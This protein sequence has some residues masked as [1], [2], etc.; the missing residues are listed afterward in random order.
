LSEIKYAEPVIVS[1]DATPVE[2]KIIARKNVVYATQVNAESARAAGDKVKREPFT[3]FGFLK[4]KSKDVEF[5]SMNK[6]YEPLMVIRGRYLIDYFRRRSYAVIVDSSMESTCLVREF[7]SCN[8]TPL[9][10]GVSVL[11]LE[12]EERLVRQVESLFVLDRQGRDSA[13]Q[14]LPSFPREEDANMAI[15][16]FGI[17][18]VPQDFDVECVRSRLVKRPSDTI[19]VVNEVFAV[20]E[21][22]V[23]YFPRFRLT[24]RDVRTGKKGVVEF[25]GVTSKRVSKE[26]TVFSRCARIVKSVLGHKS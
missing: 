26:K 19:S 12:G 22:S 14:E 23:I 21:R 13:Q 17:E 3:R 15:E 1:S 24:Y 20:S 4:P 6:F 5:V 18:E 9:H 25:D 8:V 7:S 16:K 2:E 11:N 10:D